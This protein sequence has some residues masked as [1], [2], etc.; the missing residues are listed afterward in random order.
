MR[1]WEPLKPGDLV[2][3]PS[4]RTAIVDELRPDGRRDL[5]YTD[6]DGGEAALRPE[7]LTLVKSAPCTPW[8]TRLP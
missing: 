5:R 1:Q 2:R 8:K 4:G 3:T 7:L 6:F